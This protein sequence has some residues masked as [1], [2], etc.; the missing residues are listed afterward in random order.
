MTDLT[1]VQLMS[2]GSRI[3]QATAGV[4][5][6]RE[7]LMAPGAWTFEVDDVDVSWSPDF[8]AE[9]VD[10]VRLIVGKRVPF[11]GVVFDPSTGAGRLT[12]TS[13]SNGR[14]LSWTGIDRGWWLLASR[15]ALPNP[16]TDNP[17]GWAVPVDARSGQAS[18]VAAQYITHNLGVD[19][20]EERAN[21]DVAVL[22]RQ[23]GTT[24][25]WS[26]RLLTLAELIPRVCA[27]GGIVCR[28]SYRLD[29][30]VLFALER[31]RDLSDRFR[32]HDSGDFTSAEVVVERRSASWM[33]AGG[34][35]DGA[36]RIFRVASTGA[37][38]ADRLEGFT[39]QNALTQ[40]W[41]VQAAADVQLAVA[42]PQTTLNAVL[43]DDAAS[44]V[45]WGVDVLLGDLVSVTVAG[46]R[47]ALPV[48]AIAHEITANRQVVRPVFGEAVTNEWVGLNRDI[49]GLAQRFES[50]IR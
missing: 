10:S 4:L 13:G 30:A 41:E 42:G 3:G 19:A 5:R 45:R 35:G 20:I 44:R 7:N 9:D 11:E 50:S 22:D 6:C 48:T 21:P 40:A 2:G 23:V 34:S 8:S 38:G 1:S 29:G 33:L 26:A 47:Y 43:T 46:V 14:R 18:T 28:P 12:I 39:D 15:R 16:A 36:S 31:A 17:T 37:E 27:D 25:A 32:F 49:A 24:G